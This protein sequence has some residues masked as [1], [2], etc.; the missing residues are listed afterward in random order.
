MN[1]K[2][3]DKNG[4]I[5]KSQNGEAHV[6]SYPCLSVVQFLCRRRPAVHQSWIVGPW[7]RIARQYMIRPGKAMTAATYRTSVG[8]TLMLLNG[9][10][11][12]SFVLT[13]V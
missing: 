12:I 7:I 4:A 2:N 13:T 5:P 3:T 10:P 6:H 11:L 1:T 8:T 9:D